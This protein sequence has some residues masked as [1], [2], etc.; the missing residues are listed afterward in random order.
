MKRFISRPS[1]NSGS[2]D[3]LILQYVRRGIGEKPAN[4]PD[5]CR[6]DDG[7]PVQFA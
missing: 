4:D 5:E 6:D 3:H 7:A 2:I 1:G